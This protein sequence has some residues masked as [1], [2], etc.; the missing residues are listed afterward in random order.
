MA[1]TA[2]TGV[3]AFFNCL[4]SA[5]LLA[6]TEMEGVLAGIAAGYAAAGK[7][8]SYTCYGFGSFSIYTSISA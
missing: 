8:Y 1:A 7:N 5:G 6:A 3:L 4:G 2:C